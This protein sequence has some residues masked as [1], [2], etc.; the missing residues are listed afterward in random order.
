M[1]DKCVHVPTCVRI[2]M[3]SGTKEKYSQTVCHPPYVKHD[4][5]SADVTP[6]NETRLLPPDRFTPTVSCSID[7]HWKLSFPVHR[8]PPPLPI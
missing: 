1:N 5:T 7:P 6:W 3:H 4:Y 8:H 2:I